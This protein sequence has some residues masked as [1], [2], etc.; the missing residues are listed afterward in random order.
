MADSIN[1]LKVNLSAKTLRI[2]PVVTL[3]G[4]NGVYTIQ[5]RQH[6]CKR[7]SNNLQSSDRP[8]VAKKDCWFGKNASV[9]Q[10]NDGKALISGD[11]RYDAISNAIVAFDTKLAGDNSLT[12]CP[13]DF[14][15]YD[16]VVAGFAGIFYGKSHDPGATLKRVAD[17]PKGNTPRGLCF[18]SFGRRLYAYH[19]VSDTLFA[20]E[21]GEPP[22]K[23]MSP[24]LFS[25]KFPCLMATATDL[26][27]FAG[28]RSDGEPANHEVFSLNDDVWTVLPIV[29]TAG[30]GVAGELSLPW[31]RY[32]FG[33][34][35]VHSSAFYMRGAYVM[36]MNLD[37]E[38]IRVSVHS[39]LDLPT[40]KYTRTGDFK[41]SVISLTRSFKT[42]YSTNYFSLVCSYTF[43]F[44]II[45]LY[46][47]YYNIYYG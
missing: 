41:L 2:A 13:I 6:L 33:I 12:V 45:I 26:Y 5:N 37:P 43:L 25:H 35:A 42:K 27:V 10:T 20:L 16:V 40:K 4:P 21:S 44:L 1:T 39:K 29:F 32:K 34:D 18:A 24:P 30:C 9:F 31:Q 38:S 46:Q 19:S 11:R 23:C 28:N 14:Q 17:L 47:H 3:V 15:D 36:R 8:R 7:Y 22:W